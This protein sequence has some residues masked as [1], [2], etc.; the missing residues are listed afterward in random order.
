MIFGKESIKILD[1]DANPGAGGGTFEI[2]VDPWMADF[3]MQEHYAGKYSMAVAYNRIKD[4]YKMYATG[5]SY[6]PI[7]AGFRSVKNS[8]N[9]WRKEH[10]L[11]NDPEDLFDFSFIPD[12]GQVEYSEPSDEEESFPQVRGGGQPVAR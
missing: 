5:N 8:F 10:G 12:L 9:E 3:I 7:R 6:K 1:R 2:M 4:L 11:V